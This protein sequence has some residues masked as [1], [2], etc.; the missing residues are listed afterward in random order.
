MFGFIFLLAAIMFLLWLGFKITGAILMAVVW[1]FILLPA[2]LIIG[3][4]G[5]VCCCTVILIPFGM[6]LIGAGVKLLMGI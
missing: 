5:L 6:K 1:L 4:V 2:A 3:L